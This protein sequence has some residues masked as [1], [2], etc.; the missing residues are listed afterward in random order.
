MGR[1]EEEGDVIGCINVTEWRNQK[2]HFQQPFSPSE[3]DGGLH[4]LSP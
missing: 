2:H 1:L 4:N 3:H